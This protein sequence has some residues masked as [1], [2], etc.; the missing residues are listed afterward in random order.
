MPTSTVK[1]RHQVIDPDPPG[2]HHDITLIA[3]INGDGLSDIIIGAKDGDVNLVWYENP[4]W[5]RHDMASAPELEAGGVV[6][7]VTGSGRPDVVA[8]QQLAGHELYWF[9]SP[10]DPTDRWP[11]RVIEDRFVK[12]HDQAVGDVDGDGETEIVVLS[13]RT[14][15]LVYYDI[16]PD[17]RVQP[18][19]RECCHV[20]AERIADL[21]GLVIVDA[22][23]DGCTEIIAGPNIFRPGASPHEPWTCEPLG[24][25]FLQTRVAVADLD[26]DGRLEI[27]L[28]EAERHPGRLAW[29]APP[30]WRPHILRDDLFHA[31][32]LAIADFNG[33]GLPDIFT[34]E[35]GLGRNGNPRMFIY[36]NRG[37]G[38]FEEVVFQEGVPTHEAKVADLTGDGR[39][40]IVGK[41]YQPERHI[42][43]WFNES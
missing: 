2:S 14:R 9:E 13:Q 21:E 11:R 39:P 5:T 29:C 24:L 6:L 34:A 8:G 4:S 20:I 19:P 27:A 26:G 32:S 10:P 33:D 18:W 36:V 17:P 40:D 7:D 12:Y 15:V 23:G 43:V 25:D 22:D 30:D 38:E 41:P 31:H 28:S 37:G 3:D 35:M 16:P 42:D 1:L